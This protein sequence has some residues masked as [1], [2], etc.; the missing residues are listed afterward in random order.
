MIRSDAVLRAA[1]PAL[2]TIWAVCWLV[3][4]RDVK[5]ARWREGAGTRALHGVPLFLCAVLL[6]GPRWL[7][8]ALMQR[9]VPA[10]ITVPTFGALLVA[11]GLGIA[12]WARWHLGR[13]WSGWVTVKEDHALIRSGPYRVVRHPI[14]SGL[15][16]AF[17]GTALAIGEWRGVVAVGLALFGFVL[18]IRVEETRMR[19]TFPEYEDYRRRS[20]ALIPLLF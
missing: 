15:L 10:G 19:E 20:A 17:L 6:A 14:Y 1:I 8:P 4:S 7:P 13:N 12:L 3:A 18:K 16:L 9:I 2:W 5:R 11:A